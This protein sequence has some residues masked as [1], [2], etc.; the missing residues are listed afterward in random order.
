MSSIGFGDLFTNDFINSLSDFF[1]LRS[2][3][4]VSFSLLIWRLSSESNNKNSDDI[5]I[6]GFEVLD[7]LDQ[8]FSFLDYSR[9]LIS[10]HIN[11][12]EAGKGITSSSIINNKFDFSPSESILVWSKIRLNRSNNSSSDAIFNFSWK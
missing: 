6:L 8:C 3:C 1:L 9:E 10:S 2:E 4:V 7:G 12:I 11:T 5:T